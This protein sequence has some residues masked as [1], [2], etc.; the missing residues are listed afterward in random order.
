MLVRQ[1]LRRL[2]GSYA[3]PLKGWSLSFSKEIEHDIL[4][5]DI[6]QD[7]FHIGQQESSN[8]FIEDEEPHYPI[9]KDED[10]LNPFN[11][12]SHGRSSEKVNSN[13]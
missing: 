7:T 5:K 6:N 2:P 8:P 4:I 9:I 13:Q 3:K 11:S 10:A 1:S 12:G